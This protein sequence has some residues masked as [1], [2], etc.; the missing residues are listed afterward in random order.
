MA[1]LL[2]Q[3]GW[4]EQTSLIKVTFHLGREGGE[5]VDHTDS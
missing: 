3:M 2:F 1:G 5:G 4:S